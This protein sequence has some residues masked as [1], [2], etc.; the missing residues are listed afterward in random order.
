[1]HKH[2]T[3]AIPPQVED[4]AFWM[5]QV[6]RVHPCQSRPFQQEARVVS[7]CGSPKEGKL[8]VHMRG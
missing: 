7:G 8:T 1:M 6:L 3:L 2:V 5:V 4:P